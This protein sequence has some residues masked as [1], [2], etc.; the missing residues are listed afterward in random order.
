MLEPYRSS[1]IAGVAVLVVPHPGQEGR[2]GVR[3]RIPGPQGV[4]GVI[5]ILG[6]SDHGPHREIPI[7]VE[8]LRVN[9]KGFISWLN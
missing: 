8:L 1:V 6:D 5:L 2:L 4:T 7:R 3:P 9:D